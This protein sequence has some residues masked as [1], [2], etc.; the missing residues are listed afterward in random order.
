MLR[1]IGWAAMLGLCVWVTSETITSRTLADESGWTELFNGKNLDG[2]KVWLSKSD[3]PPE[4][5]ISVK[6]GVIDVR[7]DVRGYLIS[8]KEY[9]NFVLNF[10]W[11]WSGDLEKKRGRNSGAF[12]RV[13]GPDRIWPKG[14]E[15][16]LMAGHAGDFWL[17][18]GAKLT[19]D[20]SRQDKRVARHYF[21]T[22]D[23]VEKPLGQWNDYK[24]VCD[25]G[26]IKLFINGELVNEGTDCDIPKGKI[27]FQSEGAPI[28]FR[29]IKIKPL[30]GSTS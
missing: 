8:D 21:R 11:R 29:N 30:T 28:Q 9:G 6:D 10:Q 17:V 1:F 27:L 19:I 26:T 20:K 3:T 22:K 23:G 14:V 4:E 18:G 16:Q 5:E 12:V 25:G 24:I 15:A 7:G 13:I 2:W